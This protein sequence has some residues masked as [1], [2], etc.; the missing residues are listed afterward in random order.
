MPIFFIMENRHL[1]K[2]SMQITKG[3]YSKI[4]KYLPVQRGNV[5]IS[6]FQL[7]NATLYVA[8]NGCSW[9]ALPSSYG[10]WHTI[11][12]RVNRWSKNGVL[13][14]LFIGFQTERLIRIQMEMVTHSYLR[15]ASGDEDHELNYKFM[16]S[17]HLTIRLTNARLRREVELGG[18]IEED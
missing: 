10:N 7:V 1:N 4:E 18:Q 6:N 17:P 8:Q 15:R 3:Q 9:R 13:Q 12:T 14:R 11:Y 16:W 5:S 2:D